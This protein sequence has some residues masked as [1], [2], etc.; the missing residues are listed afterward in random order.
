V[1]FHAADCSQISE[2][3][4]KQRD[5]EEKRGDYRGKN[6]RG[7]KPVRQRERT[8]NYYDGEELCGDVPA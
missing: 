6:V 7:E 4:K 1:W 8:L 5:G 2:I 3:S